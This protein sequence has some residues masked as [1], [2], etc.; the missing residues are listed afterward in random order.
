MGRD[1]QGGEDRWRRKC[2]FWG[3]SASRQESRERNIAP[4]RVLY[5][6]AVETLPTAHP[7][8]F[9]PPA[10]LGRLDVG[11]GQIFCVTMPG[12]GGQ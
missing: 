5:W 10:F 11:Q 1:I 8:P 2:V 9:R 6:R 3:A 4:N 12:K 7:P